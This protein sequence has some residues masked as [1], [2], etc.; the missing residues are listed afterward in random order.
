M[1][2]VFGGVST[3]FHKVSSIVWFESFC[4]ISYSRAEKGFLKLFDTRIYSLAEIQ[5]RCFR[6]EETQRGCHDEFFFIIKSYIVRNIL[7]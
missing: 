2:S 6:L 3:V 1:R 4:S 5:A 7:L